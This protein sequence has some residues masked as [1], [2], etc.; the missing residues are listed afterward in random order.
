LR[1]SSRQRHH[2]ARLARDLAT[3]ELTEMTGISDERAV[4]LIM[5]ARATGS[6]RS[7]TVRPPRRREQVTR[8]ER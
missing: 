1:A 2:D 7:R 8:Q 4:D 6:S 3:D 5:K